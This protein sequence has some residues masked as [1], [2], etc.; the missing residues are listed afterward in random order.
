M[1]VCCIPG[2][3]NELSTR[4]RLRTCATCRQSLHSWERRR[5]AEILERAQRL[6]KYTARMATF[7]VVQDDEV[8][9]VDHATL[10]KKGIMSFPVRKAKKK[11]KAAI[12][13]FKLRQI[14]KVTRGA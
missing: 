8:N 4:T 12:V 2:C 3:D 9:L 13:E 1:A 6:K 11:A 5:P 14:K 7:A 10:Q